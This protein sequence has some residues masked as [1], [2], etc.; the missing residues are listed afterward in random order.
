VTLNRKILHIR[1]R[2]GKGR[3]MLSN[4]NHSIFIPT[5]LLVGCGFPCLTAS[6]KTECSPPHFD[7]ICWF[8]DDAVKLQSLNIHT[9]C[10]TSWVWIPVFDCIN[11]LKTLYITSKK[12]CSPPPF[13]RICWFIENTLTDI[14]LDIELPTTPYDIGSPTVLLLNSVHSY[15]KCNH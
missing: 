8:I 10:P 7:R 15:I 2:C 3:V 4:S 12:E 9:D 1:F 6:K 11:E 13:D 5:A 14:K